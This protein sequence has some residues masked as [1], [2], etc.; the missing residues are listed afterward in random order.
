METNSQVSMPPQAPN[1]PLESL[2][3]G[4]D[5]SGNHAP[6]DLHNNPL[7]NSI[8]RV[9][10]AAAAAHQR[11]TW[12]LYRALNETDHRITGTAE[13]RE[14]GAYIQELRQ[15]MQKAQQQSAEGV[16]VQGRETKTGAWTNF[17]ASPRVQ[18]A[19][20]FIQQSDTPPPAT[21]EETAVALVLTLHSWTRGHTI[22][23]HD[24]TAPPYARTATC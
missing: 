20:T 24:K 6:M 5:V 19:L 10:Q 4:L 18:D 22:V 16:V 23:L 12:S 17:A 3:S 21:L 9:L 1:A 7:Q 2:P 11:H 15:D 14:P 13:N 8:Q